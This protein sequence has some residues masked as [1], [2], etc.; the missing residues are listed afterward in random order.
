MCNDPHNSAD[1][2][3]RSHPTNQ[4]LSSPAFVISGGVDVWMIHRLSPVLIPSAA[5]MPSLFPPAM[6]KIVAVKREVITER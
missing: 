5:R 3:G 6:I 2:N 4:R 1:R